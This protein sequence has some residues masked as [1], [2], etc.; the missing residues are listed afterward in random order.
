VTLA[1]SPSKTDSD[2]ADTHWEEE[3]R[4]LN[5]HDFKLIEN[6]TQLTCHQCHDR[7]GN[8]QRPVFEC[9]VCSFLCHHHCSSSILL[10]CPEVNS[11]QH[12]QVLYVMVDDDIEKGRWLRQL[13]LL[14][15]MA[16]INSQS[17]S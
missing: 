2:Y 8:S 12:G 6:T 7:I 17:I 11:L 13:D 5:K 3:A 16:L 14:R 15:M 4:H 10:S 1:L 9:T